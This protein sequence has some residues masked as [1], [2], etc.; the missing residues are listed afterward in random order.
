MTPENVKAPSTS[1]LTPT[2]A[3][4]AA[5]RSLP[6]ATRSRPSRVAAKTMAARRKYAKDNETTD[7]KHPGDL[8][9]NCCREIKIVGRN[10]LI[11]GNHVRESAGGQKAAECYGY[12]SQVERRDHEPLQEA[13]CGADADGAKQSDLG[14]FGAGCKRD[15]SCKPEYPGDR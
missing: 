3:I 1:F 9:I 15:T 5:L 6:T 8:V 10:H 2:P 13:E 12:G 4:M 14:I 11:V 7:R